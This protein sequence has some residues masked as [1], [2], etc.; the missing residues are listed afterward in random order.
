MAPG[1]ASLGRR[2]FQVW[3]FIFVFVPVKLVW[4]DADTPRAARTVAAIS[5][6]C[7]VGVTNLWTPD[8]LLPTALSLVFLV[9]VSASYGAD[10]SYTIPELTGRWWRR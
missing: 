1:C 7:W 8:Y 4:P 5:F 2:S 10:G 3:C 6:C 9:L